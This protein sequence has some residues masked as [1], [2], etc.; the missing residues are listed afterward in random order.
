MGPAKSR[1]EV[2]QRG[3]VGDIHGSQLQR[4]FQ[5]LSMKQV[6]CADANVEQVAGCN[7]GRILVRIICAWRRKGEARRPVIRRAGADS[8][9]D[10]GDLIPTKKS[11]YLPAEQV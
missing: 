4:C 6:I 11:R 1:Q 2:V 7:A 9:D 5:F 10:G 3:F 8:V